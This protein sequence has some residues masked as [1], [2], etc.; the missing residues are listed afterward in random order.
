MWADRGK[1]PDDAEDAVKGAEGERERSLYF[2]R[3]SGISKI[4]SAPGG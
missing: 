2:V 4:L 1:K 3:S